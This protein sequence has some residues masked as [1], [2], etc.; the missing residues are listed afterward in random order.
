MKILLG[1][2]KSNMG[3][4][5]RYVLDLATE[6]SK[7]GHQVGVVCG[8][9]GIL[10]E[11]L[12]QEKIFP[13]VLEELD[14]EI[15]F[16]ND[17]SSFFKLLKILYKNRPDVFHINSSKMGAVGVLAG[18]LTGVKK[19]IFTSHGWTFNEPRW[20]AGEKRM[21]KFLYWIII[22]LSHKTICVSEKLKKD[23]DGFPWVQDKF[24]IIK[25]GINKFELQPRDGAREK[26]IP[27]V[28]SSTTIVGTLSELHKVKGL[29]VLLEVW[30]KFVEGKNA[31]LL[32]TGS[33]EERVNL[34]NMAS[35]MG[36]MESVY[37]T[38]YLDNA[39]SYLSTFD[40]FVMPSRSE[41]LPYAL[42]EAGLAEKP[43]IASDVGG[44]PEVIDD[45]RN[46]ILVNA[47]NKQ[48]LLEALTVL[49]DNPVDRNILGKALKQTIETKF[50]LGKMVSETLKTYG[51]S[52]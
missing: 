12:K 6:L 31:K 49:Y 26:L 43:V 42:L 24:V 46:G 16:K 10:I 32:I 40:I 1:I 22:F 3:G 21:I 39:R 2:T 44:V 29:D 51:N 13:L 33:G 19:I 11:K 48:Q 34:H 18:R 4:A 15:S 37:F 47:G 41:G 27:N 17:L 9:K 45:K 14:R 25:N 30:R 35:N 38:D 5:Q 36:I 23:V 20:S 28:L 50:S 52:K 7:E 8:G